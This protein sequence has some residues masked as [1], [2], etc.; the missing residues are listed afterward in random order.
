MDKQQ[1]RFNNWVRRNEKTLMIL[2]RDP[3][4]WEFCKTFFLPQKESQI[5]LC[6]LA[7]LMKMAFQKEV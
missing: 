4:K 3:G 5:S 2:M 7:A 1:V 6:D